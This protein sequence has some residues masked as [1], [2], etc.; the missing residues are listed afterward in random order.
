MSTVINE[1]WLSTL[2]FSRGL[3]YIGLPGVNACVLCKEKTH[4]RISRRNFLQKLPKELRKDFEDE[5]QAV[6][7]DAGVVPRSLVGVRCQKVRTVNLCTQSERPV[8]GK[9]Q[10]IMCISYIDRFK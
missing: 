4:S 9:Y 6:R 3:Q 1:I 8:S 2:A 10:A 5:A 7:P